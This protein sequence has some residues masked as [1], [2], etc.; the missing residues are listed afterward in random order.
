MKSSN[1]ININYVNYQALKKKY[2]IIINAILRMNLIPNNARN[3][4]ANSETADEI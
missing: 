2:E 3:D 4:A 1:I